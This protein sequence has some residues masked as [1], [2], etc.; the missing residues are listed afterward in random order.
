MPLPI[1][2]M[3]GWGGDDDVGDVDDHDHD[4][5]ERCLW[6]DAVSEATGGHRANTQHFHHCLLFLSLCDICFKPCYKKVYASSASE[7]P[8]KLQLMPET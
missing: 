3:D 8:V 1:L 7:I 2:L 5:D 4:E 6:T